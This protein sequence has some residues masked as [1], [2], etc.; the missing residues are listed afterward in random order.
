MPLFRTMA[1]SGKKQSGTPI[2]THD[3]GHAFDSPNLAFWSELEKMY[4][5]YYRKWRVVGPEQTV[6]WVSRAV[7]EDFI[8]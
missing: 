5:C 2:I 8:D 4:V 7:S 1:S 3:K 6:R